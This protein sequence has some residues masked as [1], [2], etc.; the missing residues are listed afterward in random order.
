MPYREE[1][2]LGC[3]EIMGGQYS[4]E[5][6]NNMLRELRGPAHESELDQFEMRVA[7]QFQDFEDTLDYMLENEWIQPFKKYISG[8]LKYTILSYLPGLTALG[9][10]QRRILVDQKKTPPA[11]IEIVNQT[12][13]NM[14]VELS[15]ETL[16]QLQNIIFTAISTADLQ[17]EEKD[18]LLHRLKNLPKDSL[19]GLTIEIIKASIPAFLMTYLN[20]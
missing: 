20:K 4:Q 5:E 2:I 13:I 9:H 15:P 12:P 8:G 14:L 7:K 18:T 11:Q 6:K 10:E 17:K 19:P 3:L 16:D 1:L